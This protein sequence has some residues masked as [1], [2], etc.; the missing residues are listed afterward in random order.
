MKQFEAVLVGLLFLAVFCVAGPSSA[1]ECSDVLRDGTLRTTTY[2]RSEYYKLFVFREFSRMTWEQAQDQSSASGAG[3]YA[4]LIFG[5]GDYSRSEFE[6]RQ[7]AVRHTLE[8][9]VSTGSETDFATIS[10][11]PGILSAWSACT[12]SQ[13]GHFAVTARRDS[14]TSAT[15][16][17]VW[18]NG[19]TNVTE[20]KLTEVVL[21]TGGEILGRPR[22]TRRGFKFETNVSCPIQIRLADARSDATIT[23]SSDQGGADAYIPPRLRIAETH[24]NYPLFPACH[25]TP[26]AIVGDVEVW[27]AAL[28]QI[29]PARIFTF[30][31]P[32]TRAV[33]AYPLMVSPE[34]AALG[35]R[36]DPATTRAIALFTIGKAQYSHCVSFEQITPLSFTYGFEVNAA[37]GYPTAVCSILP[38]AHLIKYSL[39]EY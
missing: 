38:S 26:T 17:I 19:A 32:G 4:Q 20:A 39:V 24:K 7:S 23:I 1:S 35:W 30:A 31:R 2:N 8:G 13:V 37:S 6:S 18:R 36:F 16:S 27:T 3:N 10:G 9:Q 22:C 25:D 28:N 21:V 12:A 5:R 29:C 14:A 34:D 15:I 11:D 33:A